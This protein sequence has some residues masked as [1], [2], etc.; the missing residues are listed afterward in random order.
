MRFSIIVPI[1]K[2]E[3]YLRQCIESILTQDYTDYELLLIDDGSPDSCPAICDEYASKD[4]RIK[5]V[6]KKNGGLVSA[7]K[8][9]A[10]VAQ[11]EYIL[12]VDGDDW[13]ADGYL[14]KIENAI[15]TS[16][17][18][19]IIAWGYTEKDD[20]AK[21]KFVYAPAEGLYVGERLEEIRGVY[22]YDKSQKGI[23]CHSIILSIWSKAV[24]RELYFSCQ[25][26]VDVRIDKGEDAIL[27][28]DIL[29]RCHSIYL[30]QYAGY[31]YRIVNNS[32][33][34]KVQGRDF[35]V[36][37]IL[38][39]EMQERITKRYENQIRCYCLSRLMDLFTLLARG[40]N[41]KEF[42]KSIKE[43]LDKDLL[44]FALKG[45]IYRKRLKEIVKLALLKVR[46]WG[47][48][49]TILKNY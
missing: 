2:V 7:R 16:G 13:I 10:E 41:K 29:M 12:N 35:E 6:H 38:I 22:L 42:K 34:R 4:N 17:N 11:G 21:K 28:L 31:N 15:I 39:T 46:A 48:L 5:V 40:G 1:Y 20:G 43:N 45:K 33:M 49:Y 9:G 8:A 3:K 44:A 19:D 36:L 24:K 37:K 23:V 47:V 18:A 14:S 26:L 32:M 27:V 30:L 25:R